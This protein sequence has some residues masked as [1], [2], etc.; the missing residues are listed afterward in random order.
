MFGLLAAYQ[1]SNLIKNQRFLDL[2]AVF[3]ENDKKAAWKMYTT[4]NTNNIVLL[5][6]NL[7]EDRELITEAMKTIV[8]K[9]RKIM[10]E[11][12]RNCYKFTEITNAFLF[13]RVLRFLQQWNKS[14]NP[15]DENAEEKINRLRKQLRQFKRLMGKIAEL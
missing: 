5:S 2:P 7:Q 4:L 14:A 15:S 1:F 9:A 3:T 11:E 13:K 12:G 6:Q 8:Y 10:V